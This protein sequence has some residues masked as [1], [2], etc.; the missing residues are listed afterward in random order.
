MKTN[1]SRRSDA[2]IVASIEAR[3]S[4][5]RLPGKMLSDINGKPTIARVVERLKAVPRLDDIVIATTTNPADDPL[6]RWAKDNGV[7]VFRGSEDDVLGRVVGAQK[8]A[9]ST[10]VIEVT[11]DTPLLCPEVIENGIAVWLSGDADVVHN[12]GGTQTFPTGAD[13]QVFALALLEDVASRISDPAIRE[14]VS[15]Y[16]Y[17]HPEQY[18]LQE[19]LAPEKWHAPDIRLQLD[20]DEDLEFIRAVFEALEP[21][22]GATFGLDP[23]MALL[24][25]NPE[26]AAINRDCVEKAPR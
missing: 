20:Y 9:A 16:F 21:Q 14:H 10:T 13:V 11:G 5:S 22:H 19:L 26:L 23:I 3:M 25:T 7:A 18:R 12:T 24:R 4:S 15:L 6:A 8:S 17:E 1:P 2:R